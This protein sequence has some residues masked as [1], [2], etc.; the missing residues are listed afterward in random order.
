MKNGKNSEGYLDPTSCNAVNKVSKEEKE[1]RKLR[2]VIFS[3]CNMAGFRVEHLVLKD[4]KTG[5]VRR[6]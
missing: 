3:I 5:I 6:G 2:S 1:F 4:K